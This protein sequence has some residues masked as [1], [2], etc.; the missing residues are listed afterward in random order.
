[1]V[2][3]A[4]LGCS[5][6]VHAGCNSRGFE[7]TN[8]LCGSETSA[9]CA[10]LVALDRSG[11][12]GLHLLDSRPPRQPFLAS[13]L[14]RLCLGLVVAGLG[15]DNRVSTTGPGSRRLL[16]RGSGCMCEGSDESAHLGSAIALRGLDSADSEKT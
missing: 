12:S 15:G 4:S 9:G 2:P 8:R 11:R 5:F 1:M 3:L 10:V 6:L 7:R 13:S 16:Q 14:P